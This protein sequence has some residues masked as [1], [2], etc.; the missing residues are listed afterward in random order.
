M[1]RPTFNRF[2]DGDPREDFNRR[3]RIYLVHLEENQKTSTYQ[4]EIF[5][6]QQAE[7]RSSALMKENFYLKKYQKQLR[8]EIKNI[9]KEHHGY[10]EETVHRMQ[11]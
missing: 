3:M 7:E 9:Y 11:D 2:A 5:R 8:S 1:N 4:F 6:R 10:Q